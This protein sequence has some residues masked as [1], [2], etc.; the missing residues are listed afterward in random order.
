MQ[1]GNEWGRSLAVVGG[2]NIVGFTL[3]CFHRFRIIPADLYIVPSEDQRGLF[4]THNYRMNCGMFDLQPQHRLQ[5]PEGWFW[6]SC[7]AVLW[8]R[9]FHWRRRLNWIELNW[10]VPNRDGIVCWLLAD[11]ILR[12]SNFGRLWQFDL[13]CEESRKKETLLGQTD[14]D[15]MFCWSIMFP[16]TI[17]NYRTLSKSTDKMISSEGDATLSSLVDFSGLLPFWSSLPSI[18]CCFASA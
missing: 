17:S 11:S 18:S 16:G 12:N 14:N 4:S 1:W 2:W 10:I 13:W 8:R 3:A 7:G 6:H 15:H 5:I 9:I